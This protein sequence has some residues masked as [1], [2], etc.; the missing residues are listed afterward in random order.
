MIAFYGIINIESKKKEK[1][2]GFL[3]MINI[4]GVEVLETIKQ[5]SGDSIFKLI[6]TLTLIF[7]FVNLLGFVFGCFVEMQK[8]GLIISF[9]MSLVFIILLALIG[10]SQ[11]ERGDTIQYKVI[12]TDEVNIEEFLEEFKIIQQEGKILTIKPVNEG[13]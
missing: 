10:C 1:K 6:I 9:I 13:E 8:E 4:R 5:N 7:L 3:K 11:L 12:L 2:E